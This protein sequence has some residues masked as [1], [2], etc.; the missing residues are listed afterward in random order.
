MT[1]TATAPCAELRKLC[2]C[3]VHVPSQLRNTRCIFHQS[4]QQSQLLI[5]NLSPYLV[6]NVSRIGHVLRNLAVKTL[7]FRRDEDLCLDWLELRES[8]RHC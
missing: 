5:S 2:P 8:I 1:R 7:S 6:E 3:L 4:R